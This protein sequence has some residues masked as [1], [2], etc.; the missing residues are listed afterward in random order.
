[1]QKMKHLCLLAML[2]LL[3]SGA[4]IAFT[5]DEEA[6]PTLREVAELVGLKVGAAAYTYHLDNARH[7]AV[8][9][10]EFNVLTPEQEA[11]PCEVQRVRGRYD[12]FNFDRLVAFADEHNMS[13]RGHTLIWHE[14]TP[15]WVSSGSFT[16]EEAIELLRDHITTVVG[17]YAGKIPVWDVVNEGIADNAAIRETPWQRLIGDDYMALAF[18]FAHEADPDA[19]LFYNDYSIEGLGAKSNTVYAMARD[20]VERGIPIHG[21][22]FQ[23]HFILGGINPASLRAN[24]QR[25]ADLGLAVHFTEV[26][27]RFDGAPT[28]DIQRQ[29]ARDYRTVLNLCLESAAC[30]TFIVWGVSDRF[31]WLRGANLGFYYNPLV[32]PLLF[33]DQY[34]P[35][36]AYFAVLNLLASE[37]GLPPIASDSAPEVAADDP[38]S[39]TADFALPEPTRS[40]PDQLAPDSVAGRAYYA[41]F[42]V[43][44]TLDGETDDWAGI[45]RV[46]VDS[47]TQV[48]D[49]NDTTLT[50]AAAADDTFLYLL[51]DVTDSTIVYGHYSI[52]EWYREDSVEFYLNAT[53]DLLA[54]FYVPGIVQMGLMAAN[55]ASPDE[56]LFGGVNSGDSGVTFVVVET[57]TGYVIE[58]AVPLVTAVWDITPAHLLT[59]GFQAHLNGSSGTDRDTKLIWSV[60]DRLDQSWQNP[61]LFGRLIFWEIEQ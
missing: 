29:Q 57:P 50:F 14:C 32:T 1:M 55:L 11:K 27:I 31:T 61:A 19:L 21:V 47:G 43:T 41:P 18:Q 53:D 17:R 60:Y 6:R 34:Q 4:Q 20:F 7:A 3:I 9:A 13:V 26:D 23:G 38:A 36:A 24:M 16:R 54:E 39:S 15:G 33:D 40:D 59:L 45:P 58:A 12:F 44:I 8:L 46:T 30:D 5:Q 2:A 48:P 37:A 52:G 22:G 28:E 42:P 25:F 10:S 56:P 51:A 49:D 35:K